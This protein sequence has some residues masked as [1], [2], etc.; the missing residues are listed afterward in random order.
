MLTAL[1]TALVLVLSGAHSASTAAPAAHVV[2]PI[3]LGP[4]CGSEPL[5]G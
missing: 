5:C 2:S 3:T 1:I 4:A